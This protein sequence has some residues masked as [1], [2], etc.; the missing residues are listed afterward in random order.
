MKKTI[1]SQVGSA[2]IEFVL[3]LPILLLILVGIIEFSLLFYDKAVITNAS[4][5]GARYG[6]RLKTPSYATSSEIIAYTKT[7]CENKL[8]SFST[9]PAVVNVTATP[10]VATPSFGAKLTVVVAYTYTDL[11]LHNLIASG[12][13]YNLSAT[14]VMTYE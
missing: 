7:Y 11:V 5:E 12:Q 9:T 8:I 14:T 3:I 13:Q 6:I 1:K 10:S 2:M 4:R